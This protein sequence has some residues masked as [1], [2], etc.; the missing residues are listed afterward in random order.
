MAVFFVAPAPA[1][2]FI[3]SWPATPVVPVV[4]EVL[5]LRPIWPDV[6][7]DPLAPAVPVA[8]CAKA[9]G[10]AEINPAAASDKAIFEIRM[11]TP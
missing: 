10:A 2:L 4:A 8:L 3:E 9:M 6:A 1:S 7:V 11:R 5:L